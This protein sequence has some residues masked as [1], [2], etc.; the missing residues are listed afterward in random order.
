MRPVGVVER[1]RRIFAKIVLKVTVPK[2]TM[3]F[4]DDQLCAGLRAVINGAVH[5]VQYIWDEH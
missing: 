1:W 5:R 4:Q 2:A 3:T